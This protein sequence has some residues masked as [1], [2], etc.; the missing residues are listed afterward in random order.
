MLFTY[1]T[2]LSSLAVNPVLP[3]ELAIGTSDSHVY[4]MDR[5]K[6]SVGSLV[7]PTSSILSN[8][9][10]AGLAGRSYQITSVQFSPEGDQVL[11]SFSGESVYLFDVKASWTHSFIFKFYLSL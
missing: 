6:L 9:S 2:S 11:A 5:R 10:V 3:H 4:L 1:Q 8:M 7:S